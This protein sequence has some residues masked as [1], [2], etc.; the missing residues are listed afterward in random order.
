MFQDLG[1]NNSQISLWSA[2]ASIVGIIGSLWAYRFQNLSAGATSIA[3][4]ILGGLLVTASLSSLP[5]APIVIAGFALLYQLIKVVF[6]VKLQHAIED[7]TKATVLSI[8]GFLSETGALTVFLL[9]GV[10]AQFSTNAVSFGFF[11]LVLVIMAALY[12]SIKAK[13]KRHLAKQQ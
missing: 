13:N 10:I 11:G 2:A 6:D 12:V 5:T 4:A 8:Q 1:L 9:F 3:I 7:K